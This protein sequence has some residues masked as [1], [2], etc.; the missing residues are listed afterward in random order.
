MTDAQRDLASHDV[1]QSSLARSFERRGKAAARARSHFARDL[2]V[3]SW[4]SDSRDRSARRR[5]AR[6]RQIAF[7]GSRRVAVPAA[8][9]AGTFTVGGTLVPL[10]AGG[11]AHAVTSK[12]LKEGMRG[13]SVKSLQ[14][15]LR[16][17]AD[18]VF[19]PATERALKRFQRRHKLT[20]DG[21]AGPATWAA[22]RARKSLAGA[23]TPKS[24]G[25][26]GVVRDR[27]A[28]VARLQRAL[29]IAA[30]GVFGPGTE[31]AVKAFQRAHGLT[32]DGVVGPA[33]WQA[34]GLRS[35][36]VLKRDAG[37]GSGAKPGPSRADRLIARMVAAGDRIAS[38]PYVYGGGHGDWNSRGYDCSGS[39]SYVLHGAG[40]LK[41]PMDSG[42]FQSYGQAGK[43][44]R[45]TI[46]AHGGHAFMVIDG[47]RYD[48]S[49]M[50]ETGSRWT[51]TMRSTS[52]YVARHPAGL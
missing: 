19:G 33:T 51:K 32:G 26:A 3:A 18:G 45:V 20:A 42:E 40:L 12:P 39:L 30:D 35:R 24:V 27:G 15:L 11:V 25:G 16:L 28:A 37:G 47:R 21:V 41:R 2:I 5:A 34:L 1:W 23:R 13:H 50:R 29:G 14:R 48:T 49:A 43:G 36:V 44:R 4:W 22:L 38:K 17:N 10:G 31:D 46:Y 52:G 9:L 7:A 6:E 8:L